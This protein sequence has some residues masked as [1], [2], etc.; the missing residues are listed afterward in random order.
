M[1]A[2]SKYRRDFCRMA[3]V[4]CREG[5][6]DAKLAELL[7]VAKSTVQ[8]WRREKPEFARAVTDGKRTF[9]G[10]V[11]RALYRRAVG[12][13]V[14]EVTRKRVPVTREDGTTALEV[15]E[16]RVVR[17]RVPPDPGAA[18]EWLSKRSAPADELAGLS[19]AELAAR[20]KA[21][22]VELDR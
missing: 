14:A 7:G 10:R 6:S 12:F 15:K 18:K 2:K 4:A 13:S 3:R 9:D 20:V 8:Q 1:P 21:L 16:E 19:D 5:F 11:E 22:E 17:K